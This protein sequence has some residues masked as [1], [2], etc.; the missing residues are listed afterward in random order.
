MNKKPTVNEYP[1]YY[2]S[3]IERVTEGSLTHI[4]MT[5][6]EKTI[7]L[8]S[9][10]TEA[11]ENF[12][13]ATE[14]WSLKEVIG[15]LTDTERIMAYRLLRIARGDQTPLAGYDDDQYVKVGAFHARSMVDVLDEFI[16]VRQ[17]TV[18]LIKG[19]S[20]D[21]W[22]R[23]GIANNEEISARALAYII[24]GHELHHITI[25]QEKYL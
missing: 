17:S 24:A 7:A 3:Y 11:E 25:I 14:K 5:Q 15:H 21:A 18:N 10:V 2:G 19:L 20:E 6:L 4:L 12:Q 23:K 1:T 16:S 9:G 8:L 13:Y 22:L